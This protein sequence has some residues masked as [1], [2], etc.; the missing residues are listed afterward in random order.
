[1]HPHTLR[2]VCIQHLLGWERLPEVLQGCDLIKMYTANL[3][4]QWELVQRRDMLGIVSSRSLEALR[5][6]VSRSTC[7]TVYLIVRLGP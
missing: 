7:S 6:L 1:M 5:T 4:A 2:S 3:A